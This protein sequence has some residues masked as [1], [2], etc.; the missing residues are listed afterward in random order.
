VSP[1]P[2]PFHPQV[3]KQ[4]YNDILGPGSDA[5]WRTKGLELGGN[6]SLV[7]NASLALFLSRHIANMKPKYIGMFYLSYLQVFSLFSA[8]FF[9]KP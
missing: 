7:A 5:L 9:F 1:L 4:F 8:S 2:N 6:T 3:C